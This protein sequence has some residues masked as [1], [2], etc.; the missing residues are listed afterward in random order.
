MASGLQTSKHV[1]PN[2]REYFFYKGKKQKTKFQLVKPGAQ[3]FILIFHTGNIHARVEEKTENF[4]GKIKNGKSVETLLNFEFWNFLLFV[5]L[6]ST[7]PYN[8]ACPTIFDKWKTP[9]WSLSKRKCLLFT[10]KRLRV[11]VR[12]ITHLRI[13]SWI[14]SRKLKFPQ[15]STSVWV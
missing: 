5:S 4:L 9:S 2:R 3:I 8:K 12:A 7:S 15:K 13:N 6:L 10:C 1:R 14:D 11:K